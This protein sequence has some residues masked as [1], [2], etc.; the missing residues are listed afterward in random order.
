MEFIKK[1]LEDYKKENPNELTEEQFKKIEKEIAK[2]KKNIVS[3]EYFDFMLWMRGFQ[4]RQDYFSKYVLKRLNKKNAKKVLEVG[5][6]RT[7]RLS[8]ILQQK[9]F[10]MTCI[11]PK[12]ELSDEKLGIVVKKEMFDYNY[13]LSN[14][15]FVIAQE[16]CDATEHIVRACIKQ[17]KP[18]IIALC[19]VPHKLISGEEFEEV[20]DWY[21]YLINISENNE[22]KLR[23][24]NISSVF[25]TYILMKD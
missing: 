10:E 13:D 20:I 2:R 15:D 17:N 12:V 23:V 6:G 8:K 21:K 5:C 25:E 11:D 7:Y 1:R 4:S 14:Y 16:P 19:G 22:I 24:I 3:D 18:F 9:G